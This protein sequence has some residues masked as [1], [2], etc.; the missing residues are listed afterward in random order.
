MRNKTPAQI[1]DDI[2]E[3]RN[4]QISLFNLGNFLAYSG[5]KM[6][7]EHVAKFLKILDFNKDGSISLDE[8]KSFVFNSNG[9]SQGNIDLR[10]MEHFVANIKQR[11][12][13]FLNDSDILMTPKYIDSELSEDAGTFVLGSIQ[14]D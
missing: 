11:V 5:W 12:L 13:L 1:F 8:F 6:S 7:K 14:V 9:L 3:D 10:Q 2:D 4:G